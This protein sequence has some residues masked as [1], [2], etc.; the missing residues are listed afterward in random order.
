MPKIDWFD[1]R[2]QRKILEY[3]AQN[4]PNKSHFN[5]IM[6]T[7]SISFENRERLYKNIN[8]LQGLNLLLAYSPTPYPAPNLE[9]QYQLEYQITSI[10]ISNIE[11]PADTFYQLVVKDTKIHIINKI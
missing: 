9:S 1:D 8:Y 2:L 5:H 7:L 11:Y 3:L 10:G 6:N 4:Y